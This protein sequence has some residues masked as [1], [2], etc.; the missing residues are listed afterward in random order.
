MKKTINILIYTSLI[1][2]FSGCDIFENAVIVYDIKSCPLNFQAPEDVLTEDG[3]NILRVTEKTG[4]EL[5]YEDSLVY[6][7][8]PTIGSGIYFKNEKKVKYGL[9]YFINFDCENK[10]AYLPINFINTKITSTDLQIVNNHL[11]EKHYEIYQSITNALFKKSKI[12]VDKIPTVYLIENEKQFLNYKEL[13]RDKKLRV[14]T[15]ELFDLK[16]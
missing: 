6:G 3:F 4:Y 5:K 14:L 8:P 1:L 2:F 11:Y 16:D 9:L 12:V 15:T 7:T 13:I 10:K